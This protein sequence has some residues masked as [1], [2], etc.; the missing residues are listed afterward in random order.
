MIPP[1]AVTAWG[2]DHPW[3]TREQV[4][5]DLLLSRA[6]CAI[7]ED[8]YLSQELV[9]RGGTALHKLHLD[10]PYRYS[11]DLDYVRSS[12]TGIAPLTR[13][14]SRLGT[15]L[16]YTVSTSPGNSP[17]QCSVMISTRSSQPGPAATTLTLLPPKSLGS[18]SIGSTTELAPRMQSMVRAVRCKHV[19]HRLSLPAGG[20][21]GRTSPAVREHPHCPGRGRR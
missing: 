15:E 9:F 16:G 2:T 20:R 5:Q 8:D 17:T 1:N 19:E 3:P 6:L 12:A 21:I 14:L 11:E 13:A 4:E 7:A 10:H 18:C